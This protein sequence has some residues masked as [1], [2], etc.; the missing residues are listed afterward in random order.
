MLISGFGMLIM[1]LAHESSRFVS[2]N[3][4]SHLIGIISVTLFFSAFYPLFYLSLFGD[5]NKTSSLLAKKVFFYLLLV[6]TMVVLIILWAK[7]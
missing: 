2:I 7:L 1:S 3:S 4:W 6:L 5:S